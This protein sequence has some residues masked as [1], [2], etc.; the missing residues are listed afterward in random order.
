[1]RQINFEGDVVMQTNDVT[2]IL[3]YELMNQILNNI[4][5]ENYIY[6]ESD[7]QQNIFNMLMKSMLDSTKNTNGNIDINKLNFLGNRDLN[8]IGYGAG[9]QLDRLNI[10]SGLNADNSIAKDIN[11]DIHINNLSIDEAV[12]NASKKYGVDKKL[13]LSVIQQESSFNP[14][15]TSNVGAMGL[16]QLMPDTAKELGVNNAYD[17]NQNVDGG[18][19]YLKSLLDTF[20]NYKM[21]IA[22]YN[23]GPGTVERSGK[24]ISKLP[25]ETQDYVAKVS[26]YYQNL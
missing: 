5:E 11:K 13:I 7:T 21:A 26:K 10:V 6:G 25:G 23:A 8:K 18:T 14:N 2:G 4:S 15:S 17:I 22:A 19:K 16:M 3:K 20:G 24:N 12:D 9:A 1:M